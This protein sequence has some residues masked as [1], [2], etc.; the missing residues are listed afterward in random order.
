[1]DYEDLKRTAVDT[2]KADLWGQAADLGKLRGAKGLLLTLRFSYA[3]R[4]Q[5]LL[6]E[7]PDAAW[8]ASALQ[9][10][11]HLAL[12]KLPIVTPSIRS[13]SIGVMMRD[14]VRTTLMVETI[15]EVVRYAG[16][17]KILTAGE[18]DQCLAAIRRDLVEW[19]GSEADALGVSAEV[20]TAPAP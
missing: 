10:L 7:E 8:C 5:S 19:N 13:S 20:G 2:F 18:L 17:I 1:M 14:V 15:E 16:E 12:V 3:D 9:A 4:I 6:P 11:P